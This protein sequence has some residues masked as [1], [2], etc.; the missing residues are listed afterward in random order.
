MAGKPLLVFGGNL[1]TGWIY[2]SDH[3]PPPQ[4][5]R[6]L[7]MQPLHIS[8][9]EFLFERDLI[10]ARSLDE[11]HGD[12]PRIVAVGKD[13][14]WAFFAQHRKEDLWIM[15]QVQEVVEELRFC[16]K[17]LRQGISVEWFHHEDFEDAAMLLEDLTKRI[18]NLTERL[19][20]MG[21]KSRFSESE[22][23]ETSHDP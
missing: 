20:R 5:R 15:R 7:E 10:D 23:Q 2:R 1:L 3:R 19:D 8:R 4:S 11:G 6:Q 9:G 18:S 22:G 14:D 17:C 21:E 16:A 12:L 13:E